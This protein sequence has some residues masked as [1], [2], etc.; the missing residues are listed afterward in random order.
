MSLTK[1]ITV[2]MLCASSLAFADPAAEKEQEHQRM[3]TIHAARMH[4]EKGNLENKPTFDDPGVLVTAQ[5][6]PHDKK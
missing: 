5:R 1:V 6:D 4:A 3:W 2:L